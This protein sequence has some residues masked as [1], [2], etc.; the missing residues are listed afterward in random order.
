M[1]RG[2]VITARHPLWLLV[3]GIT[4]ISFRVKDRGWLL[5]PDI[6]PNVVKSSPLR[7]GCI[8]DEQG[9]SS[10][11]LARACARTNAHAVFN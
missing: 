1:V 5:D 11:L 10:K 4:K 9:A 3:A 6:A 8:H 7:A 2:D